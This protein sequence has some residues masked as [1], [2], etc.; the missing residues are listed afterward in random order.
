MN[1]KTLT[2]GW[3]RSD[4]DLTVLMTVNLRN[5]EDSDP[6]LFCEFER[7][8]ADLQKSTPE[9]KFYEREDLPDYLMIDTSEFQKEVNFG[10]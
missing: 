8:L 2:I 10:Y 3:L 6:E 5:C 1:A 4:G 7:W 9:L